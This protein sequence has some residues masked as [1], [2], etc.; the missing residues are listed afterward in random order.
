MNNDLEIIW[1]EEVTALLRSYPG[2]SSE[3]LRKT[4]KNSECGVPAEIRT[5]HFRKTGQEREHYSNVFVCAKDA[6]FAHNME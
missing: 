6:F 4:T 3:V 2:N 5:E 1:K